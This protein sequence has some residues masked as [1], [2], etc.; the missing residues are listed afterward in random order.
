MGLAWT[1]LGGTTLYMSPQLFIQRARL[2]QTGQL[3]DVMRR[4]L[5]RIAYTYIQSRAKDYGI[6]ENF[7]ANHFYTP[8]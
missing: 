7:F 5:R 8:S 1:S 4:V 2:K 3:R 6:D